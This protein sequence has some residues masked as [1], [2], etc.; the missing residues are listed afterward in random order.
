MPDPHSRKPDREKLYH[1][2]LDQILGKGGTGTV[3]RGIDENTGEVAA[4]KLFRANFFRNNLHIKDLAKSVK[5]FRK[6]SHQNVVGIHEFIQGDEG[7][8]LVMEYV[9]GPDLRWYLDNRPWN[10]NERLV[11]V[12][13]L[14]NGLQYLHE[15]GYIHHDFKPS[16]V[17]FTRKGVAK[18]TD[19]S[20]C[21]T[22]FFLELFDQGMG[23]EQ[24]TPLY[25]APELIRKEKA[26]PQSDMYSLGIAMY[27]M[28]ADKMP[29]EMD[30]LQALYQCHLR[31]RPLHPT[32]INKQCP[33]ALGD[34][35]M[36]LLEK[37]P[38]KRFK[39]CDQLRITIASIGQSRI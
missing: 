17:I 12:A 34:I 9:D 36:R 7:E 26:T 10:L 19:F 8:C 5:K 31:V 18:L 39:D 33:L 21:G 3:Y 15:R 30:N 6:F 24:V 29:F 2:R 11:I 14:C 23:H 27:Q 4:I 28:F 35:I 13:Q 1:Y 25:L 16:N 20:L 37:D 38:A 22:N 32:E